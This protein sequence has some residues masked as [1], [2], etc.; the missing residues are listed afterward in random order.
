MMRACF[1]CKLFTTNPYLGKVRGFGLARFLFF[2]YTILD[3]FD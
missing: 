1:Y 2:V 3:F